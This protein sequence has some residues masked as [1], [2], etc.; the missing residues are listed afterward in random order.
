MASTEVVPGV[1]QRALPHQRLHD[2]YW[3]FLAAWEKIWEQANS[4]AQPALQAPPSYATFH[5]RWN[6][7]WKK[8]MRFRKSSEHAQC[9]TC[10]DLL[11]QLHGGAPGVP[12]PSCRSGRWPGRVHEAAG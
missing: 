7:T 5:R 3:V 12:S 11:Q 6:Q 1:L 9:Q 4:A 10:F 2:L 8:Y